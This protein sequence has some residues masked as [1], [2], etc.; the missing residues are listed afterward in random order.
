MA[1]FKNTGPTLVSFLVYAARTRHGSLAYHMSINVVVGSSRPTAVNEISRCELAKAEH[2]EDM[3]SSFWT[4]FVN[5][6]EVNTAAE[7]LVS[8]G[9]ICV[10]T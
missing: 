4:C 2:N 5:A 3:I 10:S 8:H 9:F 6:F 7:I 1:A